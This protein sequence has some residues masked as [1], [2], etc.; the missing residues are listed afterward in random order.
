MTAACAEYH[1]R[2]RRSVYV[3][4]KSYMSFL[5]GYRWGMRVP[6]LTLPGGGCMVHST[7]QVQSLT[8]GSHSLQ[9][10][11][12]SSSN[13]LLWS[14]WRMWERHWHEACLVQMPLAQGLFVSTKAQLWFNILRALFITASGSLQVEHVP[15]LVKGAWH[16]ACCV[17]ES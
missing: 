17:I 6:V 8:N 15:C 14:S 4:P 7:S 2:F 12:T 3:T 11:D 10:E 1:E 13:G 5:E 16:R 9:M